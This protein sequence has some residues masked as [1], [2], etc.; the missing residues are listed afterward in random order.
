MARRGSVRFGGARRGMARQ[1]RQW[2]TNAD[3][4]FKALVGVFV[5]R[6]NAHTR[7]NCIQ[8]PASSPAGWCFEP[9]S[10]GAG[11]DRT[12]SRSSNRGTI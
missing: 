4:S 5:F 1:G 8:A 2:R 12:P 3:R 6:R 10:H 11:R 9:V 7:A